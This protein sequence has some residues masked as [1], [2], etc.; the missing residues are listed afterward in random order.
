MDT[1]Q[2]LDLGHLQYDSEERGQRE[3]TKS[4]D[5]TGDLGVAESDSDQMCGPRSQV[6]G[7]FSSFVNGAEA[8][9]NSQSSDAQVRSG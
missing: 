3:A 6:I 8:D 9:L 5:S 1:R 4:S 7:F 2:G